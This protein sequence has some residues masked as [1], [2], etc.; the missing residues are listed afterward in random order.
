MSVDGTELGITADRAL[1]TILG[2]EPSPDVEEQQTPGQVRERIEAAVPG[3]YGGAT[4][5]L[6]RAVLRLFT[7]RE[8]TQVW[9]TDSTYDTVDGKFQSVGPDLFSAARAVASPQELEAFDGCT[10]FM[11]GFAVNQARWLLGQHPGA[12]PA[13]LTIG[14]P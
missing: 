12:N 1:A 7:R 9:P 10:G 11:W 14:T 13:I 5:C 4:D 3:S 2:G 6:T 8:E